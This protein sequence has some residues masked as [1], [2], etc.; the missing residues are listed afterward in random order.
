MVMLQKRMNRLSHN[1][2]LIT[3]D[4]A[5]VLLLVNEIAQK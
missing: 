5:L 4:Y 3:T 2:D 1:S